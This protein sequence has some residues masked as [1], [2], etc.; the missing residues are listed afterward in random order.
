MNYPL[1]SSQAENWIEIISSLSYSLLSYFVWLH[2]H[3]FVH[4]HTHTHTHTHTHREN[5]ANFHLQ[6]GMWFRCFFF[7]I[8]FFPYLFFGLLGLCYCVGF[9]QLWQVGATLYLWYTGFSLLWLLLLRSVGSVVA[10]HGLIAPWDVESFWTKDWTYIPCIGR[11]ILNHWTTREA[12]ACDFRQCVSHGFL[13]SES[14]ESKL[15]RKQFIRSMPS[16]DLLGYFLFII[17]LLFVPANFALTV[18]R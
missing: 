17:S 10:A 2:V 12:P 14:T 18:S 7:K 15:D 16:V 8:S 4:M 3:T 6:V 13:G 5:S 9:L 1:F 11:W